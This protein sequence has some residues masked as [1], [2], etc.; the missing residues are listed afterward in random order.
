MFNAWDHS[1]DVLKDVIAVSEGKDTADFK[2]L[3][4]NF[5]IG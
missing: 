2:L 1:H 3:Y 5:I 4:P